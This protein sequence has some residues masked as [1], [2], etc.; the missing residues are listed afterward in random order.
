MESSDNSY[1]MFFHSEPQ[2]EDFTK[3]SHDFV[4][5]AILERVEEALARGETNIDL[6]KLREE[7]EAAPLMQGK[8]GSFDCGMRIYNSAPLVM[9]PDAALDVANEVVRLTLR[10][11]GEFPNETKFD[12]DKIRQAVMSA[13]N[14]QVL[15]IDGMQILVSR[16]LER[17][18][19]AAM[20][21][22]NSYTRTIDPVLR[23]PVNRGY[24]NEFLMKKQKGR[25]R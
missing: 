21:I 4:G 7:I 25:R 13:K 22:S 17:D 15:T 19:H 24:Q 16:E 11:K 23:P 18:M 1:T 6:A 20:T 9:H 2:I 14:G 12:L 8:I 5:E 3:C 10:E